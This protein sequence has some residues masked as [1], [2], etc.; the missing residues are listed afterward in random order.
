MFG[1][2]G[3]LVAIEDVRWGRSLVGAEY[4]CCR[5]DELR[6]RGGAAADAADMLVGYWLLE[7]KGAD[8]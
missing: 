3:S 5:R 4:D 6:T 1:V 8:S 7:I 2:V